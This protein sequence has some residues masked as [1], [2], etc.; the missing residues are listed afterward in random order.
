MKLYSQVQ[1]MEM[2][3]AYVS[4]FKAG[5]AMMIEVLVDA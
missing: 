3:A 5:A 1:G 4:G 2:T